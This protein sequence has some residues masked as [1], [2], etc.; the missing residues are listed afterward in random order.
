MRAGRAEHR[1]P[2]QRELS[3][4]P[5]ADAEHGE[6]QHAESQQVANALARFQLF[7]GS[8][9]AVHEAGVDERHEANAPERDD[10]GGKR[11]IFRD[12]IIKEGFV[13]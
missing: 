3:A 2:G 11:D 4:D 1:L 5:S 12:K 9:V 13:D 10:L 8:T 7:L 6:A